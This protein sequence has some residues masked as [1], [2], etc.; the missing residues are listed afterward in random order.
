VIFLVGTSQS[1]S[2]LYEWLLL[3]FAQ[4]PETEQRNEMNASRGRTYIHVITTLRRIQ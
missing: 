4:Y 1:L 3:L 2:F